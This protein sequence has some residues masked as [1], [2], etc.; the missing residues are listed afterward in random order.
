MPSLAEIAS[1]FAPRGNGGDFWKPTK[2]A[3]RFRL[4]RVYQDGK[5]NL[6]AFSEEVVWTGH[7]YL[8][9]DDND[10]KAKADW[11][12][13]QNT[14]RMLL[15]SGTKEDKQKANGFKPRNRAWLCGVLPD[16]P[17][18]FAI[19]KAPETVV[20]RILVLLATAGNEGL[21]VRFE[22]DAAFYALAE[23]GA[24][25]VCGPKGRDFGVSFDEKAPPMSMYD[26]SL[27][28]RTPATKVL[29]FS[30]EETPD[31]GITAK[32]MAEFRAKKGG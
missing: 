19:W 25:L 23:K 10:P 4:Y 20:Q 27:L 26:I 7:A 1:Q 9:R 30:E 24:D 5:P 15:S 32:R 18:G 12:G 13:V 16:D 14:R 29:P 28:E 8:T 3:K 11:D 31:P 6:I 21:P 22:N 2:D 17:K